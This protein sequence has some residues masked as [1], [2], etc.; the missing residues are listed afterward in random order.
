VFFVGTFK[1]IG[2]AVL[3]VQAL[4][5]LYQAQYREHEVGRIQNEIES[6]IA[7]IERSDA[8]RE[9]APPASSKPKASTE[10]TLLMEFIPNMIYSKKEPHAFEAAAAAFRSFMKKYRFQ[11]DV[12][13]IVSLISG[14]HELTEKE[15]RL[16]ELYAKKIACVEKED[17]QLAEEVSREIQRLRE[18]T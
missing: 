14:S 17:F 15:N 7:Q 18:K 10:E 13:T 9:S 6:I 2:N 12:A 3:S 1:N 8:P 16:L 4:P 11:E 5:M